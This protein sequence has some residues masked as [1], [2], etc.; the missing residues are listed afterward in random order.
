MNGGRITTEEKATLSS[1]LGVGVLV[2]LA[3]G[4][5]IY[6]LFLADKEIKQVTGFDPNR[7]VPTDA[8]LKRRLNAEAYAV[9]REGRTQ[10]AF[11]NQYWDEKR[12]GLYID[13]VTGEPLFSS[14]DKY[15]A[16]FGMPSFSKPISTDLL[17]E[18]LDTRYHMQRTQLQAKRS[19]SLLGHRFDDPNS[20]TGQRYSIN[21]AALRFIPLERM[22]AEGYEE[23]LPLV[24]KK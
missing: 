17:V 13:V 8:V 4:G 9:V 7:P 15:D 10:M 23:Y 5:A 2:L 6:F 14:V 18:S 11:Q 24:E 21:S 1:Y 22:K 16:G 19:K 3:L 20:P 12:P